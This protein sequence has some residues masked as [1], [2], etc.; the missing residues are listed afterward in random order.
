MVLSEGHKFPNTE[1]V[2]GRKYCKFHN[3]YGHTTNTCVRFRDT[4]QKAIEEGRLIFEEK[5]KASPMKVDTDPFQNTTN[6][7][8]PT[9]LGICMVGIEEVDDKDVVDEVIEHFE[10]NGRRIYA[11]AGETLFEFLQCKCN[12]KSEVML[13]PRCS[14]VFDLAAAKAFER[15]ELKKKFEEER[16]RETAKDHGFFI[17]DG[18]SKPPSYPFV[19][20]ESSRPPFYPR[21]FLARHPAKSY[22]PT[23]KAPVNKW[24]Q[25]APKQGNRWSGVEN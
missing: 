15:S 16:A 3:V 19:Q 9:D 22:A 17:Q 13:C 8:E 24:F 20:D 6:Y 10:E 2:R 12:E 23:S 25:G 1:Q 21:H 5:K 4:V 7:V 18:S 14:S 11:S